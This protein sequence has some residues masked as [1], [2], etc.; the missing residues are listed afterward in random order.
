MC[1]D[2]QL[3]H[4]LR[5]THLC[6]SPPCR[7]SVHRTASAH[8]SHH[9]CPLSPH[10]STRNP[11]FTALSHSVAAPPSTATLHRH[12][13]MSR[14][15]LVLAALALLVV[16][17][18]PCAS[19][20]RV[21]VS[22]AVPRLDTDG[23]PINAHDGGMYEFDGLFHLYGTAYA[24]CHQA[25]P[26]CDG[27][28]GYYYNTF[29]LY[30]SPDLVNWTL[31]SNNILPAMTTDH[32]TCPY[33]E[34]NVAYNPLTQL[35]MMSYWDGKYGYL[36]GQVAMASSNTSYGPFTPIT[37][38][39]LA[40][41]NDTGSTVNLFV[42]RHHNGWMR[43]GANDEPRRHIVELLNA[44]WTDTTGKYAV[45]FLK[46]D[47]MRYEGGGMFERH[48]LYYVMLG[49]E[50]CF[51]QWGGSARVFVATD[52]LG[53]WIDQ[54]QVNYCADGTLAPDSGLVYTQNTCSLN[55]VTGTN[56]TIP[57]QQFNVF[58]ARTASHGTLHVYFGEMFRSAPSGWKDEDGQAWI[59]LS[60]SGTGTMRP[61]QWM[62]EWTVEL[63]DRGASSQS[64][65]RA[66]DSV[67]SVE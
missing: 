42:D 50:C 52:P 19:A 64:V 31:V 16:A 12:T 53:E 58:Q 57:A 27:E 2:Q 62:D 33:W 5:V 1:D 51:C 10:H 30:T 29:S 44:N 38:I 35:Y 66:H 67:A 3:T 32:A 45:I 23:N 56:F 24:H 20:R 25:G 43:Y 46:E 55:N 21:T 59:P 34:C 6:P 4:S 60:F 15:L 36:G 40:G 7:A 28:C 18:L 47:F 63:P 11:H 41:T 26:T 17:V 65:A 54:T 37:P 13:R 22:N 14:P 39:T 9:C 8:C 49:G 48:G 61:M